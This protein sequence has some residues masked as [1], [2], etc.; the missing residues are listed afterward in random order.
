MRLLSLSFFIVFCEEE[1]QKKNRKKKTHLLSLYSLSLSTLNS[2]VFSE[3]LEEEAQM[4]AEAE[5]AEGAAEEVH[6]AEKAA[7]MES[8]ADEEV[9]R[10]LFFVFSF[11]RAR[12]HSFLSRPC[13]LSLSLVRSRIPLP[14]SISLYHSRR[15][16]PTP[17]RPRPR[18][19]RQSSRRCADEFPIFFPFFSVLFLGGGGKEGRE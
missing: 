14:L 3:Q 11:A 6:S 7:E 16:P 19:S 2:M 18:R 10:V 12:T 13:S 17:R 4:V 15:L 9:R 5:A 8:L 1:A